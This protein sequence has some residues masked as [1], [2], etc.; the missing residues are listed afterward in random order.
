MQD[1]LMVYVM[2]IGIVA[3]VAALFF[4]QSDEAVSRK[5]S[6]VRVQIDDNRRGSRVPEPQDEDMDSRV[7]YRMV[8]A[9]IIMMFVVMLMSIL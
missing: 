3:A 1:L 6:K 2:T 4:S 8:L 5:Y 7:E 9:A